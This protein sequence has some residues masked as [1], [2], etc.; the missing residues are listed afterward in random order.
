MKTYALILLTVCFGLFT[1]RTARCAT[2]VGLTGSQ[3]LVQFDTTNPSV[4]QNS[5]TIS[6]T[7]GAE[8]IADIDFYPVTGGLYGIGATT[9]TLYRLNTTTG[10][11]TVDV[12]P[13]SAISGATE[14]D[15]NPAADRL[16][17][18]AGTQNF[19]LTPSTFDNAGLTAGAVSS[20]GTLAYAT[21]DTNFGETPN[22]VGNAYTNNF[23]GTATTSLYSIDTDFDTLVLNS[24]APQFSTLGTVAGLTLAGQPFDIGSLVG[25]DV[26]GAGSAFVS[27]GNALYSLNLATAEL[28]SLGNIF[29]FAAVQ[30]IAIGPVAVPEPSAI[31]LAAIGLAAVSLQGAR[32]RL[33]RTA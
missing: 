1:A 26:S 14:I 27:N 11:A 18:F 2:A 20:D 28:T 31:A 21:G 32:R 3:Q 13:A 16:R 22:L 7:T 24:G 29:Q 10:A 23:N 9:G 25:F 5:A 30:S 4:L 17:I 8:L 19:R 6:G 33:R 15:F 12:V